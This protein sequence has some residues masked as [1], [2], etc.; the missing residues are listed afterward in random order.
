MNLQ[1]P[2][3]P[4]D[5]EAIEH[6]RNLENLQAMEGEIAQR[7][8]GLTER[9]IRF[10]EQFDIPVEDFWRDL[11]A[12][13]NGPLAAVLAIEARRQRIHEEAAAAYIE[14]MAHVDNFERLPRQGG[15]VR[16]IRENGQ[17]VIRQELEEGEPR[18]SEALDFQWQIKS[19]TC[20]AAQKYTKEGGGNQDT[21][22][23]ET[24]RLLRNFQQSGR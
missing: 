21:R 20:Y 10:S 2:P 1:Q 9:I 6:Q 17:I 7:T 24:M 13:P 15:N 12:N 11:D 23:D 16:Y 14:R 19:V 22:F 5:F 8:N 4:L 3:A 18:Q